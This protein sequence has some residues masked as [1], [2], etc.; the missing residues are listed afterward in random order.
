MAI[1]RFVS[2]VKGNSSHWMFDLMVRKFESDESREDNE[3]QV[4]NSY[5]GLT[6]VNIYH[7]GDCTVK[8]MDSRPV[9]SIY[10]GKNNSAIENLKSRLEQ[11]LGINLQEVVD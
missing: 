6:E 11:I 7:L 3:Y 2:A 8:F 1:K 5:S 4:V 9:V 10:S